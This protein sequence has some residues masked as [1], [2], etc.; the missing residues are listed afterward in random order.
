M[1][2]PLTWGTLFLVAGLLFLGLA[3]TPAGS[4]DEVSLASQATSPSQDQAGTPVA[5]GAKLGISLIST[6]VGVVLV[7]ISLLCF[8]SPLTRDEREG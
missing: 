2:R 6:L 5:S 4:G 1:K 3:Y 8:S 7:G